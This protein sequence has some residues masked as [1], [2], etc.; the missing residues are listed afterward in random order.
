MGRYV[1]GHVATRSNPSGD[2][3]LTL[4]V[5][6]VGGWILYSIINA[7]SPADAAGKAVRDAINQIPE[8]I[9][10]ALKGI[11]ICTPPFDRANWSQAL[12][13]RMTA[14][15]R[16]WCSVEAW[17]RQQLGDQWLGPI[18]VHAPQPQM[19]SN[20]DAFRRWYM[21]LYPDPGTYGPA[22][23]FAYAMTQ[24]GA[25]S[26]GGGGGGGSW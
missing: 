14:D 5:V 8:N 6:G 11:G 3:I 18:H 26:G 22:E 10:N 13:E 1:D 2:T 21:M 19:A 12:K 15:G 20:W 7:K 24:A 25:G 23:F 4:A 17:V 16:F 9:G